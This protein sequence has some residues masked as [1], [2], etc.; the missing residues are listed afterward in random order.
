[1]GEYLILWDFANRKGQRA[2]FYRTLN[3]DFGGKV[4]VLQKSAYTCKERSTAAEL[5]A[6]AQT[7]GA[8]RCNVFAV[9]GDGLDAAEQQAAKEA[10]EALLARRL[11]RRGRRGAAG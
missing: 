5:A 1:M 9:D 11:A 3:E 7:C 8:A 4:R 10:I 2:L 6:L